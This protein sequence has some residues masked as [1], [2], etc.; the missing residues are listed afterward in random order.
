[1]R[2][3]PPNNNWNEEFEINYEQN[4][5]DIERDITQVET[6]ITNIVLGDVTVSAIPV[7]GSVTEEKI[8][9]ENV[10]ESKIKPGS[11]TESKLS[12]VVASRIGP[13]DTLGSF[14][15]VYNSDGSVQSVTM[16]NGQ[17]DLTYENGQIKTVT[18][19][20]TGKTEIVSALSYGTDGTFLGVTRN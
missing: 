16:P 4:L 17:V 3:R 14:N 1:M 19:K 10:T 15:I 8:A 9:D 12:D 5:V 18:E 20:P 6:Q 2:Y 13:F 11:V 7:D